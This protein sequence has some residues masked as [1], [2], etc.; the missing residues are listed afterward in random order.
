MLTLAYCA[1]L[2]CRTLNFDPQNRTAEGNFNNPNSSKHAISKPFPDLPKSPPSSANVLFTCIIEVLHMSLQKFHAIF[3][4]PPRYVDRKRLVSNSLSLDF[5]AIATSYLSPSKQ[6]RYF[7]KKSRIPMANATLFHDLYTKTH[8]ATG[9][10]QGRPRFSTLVSPE[11]WERS[12]TLEGK[13]LEAG[14]PFLEGSALL[15]F[16]TENPVDVGT[17]LDLDGVPL[18]P[19]PP[20]KPYL[21]ADTDWSRLVV[22]ASSRKFDMDNLSPQD[23]QPWWFIGPTYAPSWRHPS[24]TPA[25]KGY[26]QQNTFWPARLKDPNLLKVIYNFY[27][28]EP[29]PHGAQLWYKVRHRTQFYVDVCPLHYEPRYVKGR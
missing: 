4:Q 6:Q 2:G 9:R 26:S 19:H 14:V 18:N 23:I 5:D 24:G 15:S 8:R 22:G 25:E 7:S 17:I 28:P 11:T 3:G 20:A 16:W 1:V 21:Q 13:A 27:M 29:L 12:G 10:A